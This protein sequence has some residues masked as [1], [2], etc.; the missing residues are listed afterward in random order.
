MKSKFTWIFTLL[1]AF[2]IQFS[3]AQDRVITGVV[4]DD[5]GFPVPGADVMISGV[6]P[7]VQTD[8][9]GKFSINAKNGDKLVVSFAGFEA[10]TITV[11]NASVL[12][13]QLGA[14]VL[15]DV[16]VEAY[17]TTSKA[18]SSI[19]AATVTSKT[20]ENR[21]NASFVQILQ[22]QV[23]G[24][25]ISSGSGQPGANNTTV[26]LRGAGSI[27]GNIEPL[28]VIDGVPQNSDN[29]RSINPAD[30]ES[31]SVLKDA[32]ATSIYG[33]RGANGV[34]IVKTKRGRYD[35]PLTIKYSGIT[36]FSEMQKSRYDVLNSQQLLTLQRTM[37]T[38][39]GG[40]I[41]PEALGGTNGVAL[42]D[43]QIAAA[44][45]YDWKDYFF[46]TG[47]SQNHVL[48]LSNGSKNLSSFT[49]LAFLKQEGIL[50][51]TDL[52]RFNFRSNLNGKSDNDKFN[53]STSLTINYSVSNT[54]SNLGSGAVNQNFVVG[55]VQG[56]PYLSPANYI[57]G[58]D[59]AL[60][61]SSLDYT[62]LFLYDKLRNF[63]N[64][65]D[66]VKAIGQ[67]QASY[68]ITPDLTVGSTFGVD[69]TN[70]IGLSSQHPNGFTPLYFIQDTPQEYTG[71]Q[72]ESFSR[73]VS[74]TTNT[75]LT[76]NKTFAEKHT[77]EAS[78]FTEYFKAHAKGFGYTQNGLDPIFF[79]PGTS[80]GW[81]AYQ[82]GNSYYVPDASSS[83]A[84]AGLFSYFGSVDYDYDSRFGLNA[85]VRRDASFRFAD[86]NKWGTFWSVSG[87]WNIDR[88][89]FMQGS[90][91]DMLKLRGS[92]G[93]AGNQDITGGGVFG[94]PSLTRFQYG[95]SSGY[96]NNPAYA[97][98][99]LRNPDLKWETIRQID[100]G[101][102]FEL[103]NHK[104]RGVADV[105]DKK[106]TDLYQPVPI[107]AVNGNTSINSNFG[108]LRNR[109]VELQLS[110]DV[111]R[112]K[113]YL[114]TLNFNGSYNK[115][116]ILKL[117]NEDGLIWDGGLTADREG[118]VISQYYLVKY[119][120]VNPA[121]G[122]L[123]FY[124][125]DGALTES[126]T[127][128]DRKFN[129]KSS[130]PKYQGS[131]GLDAEYK[132]FFINTMFTYVADIYRFDY[133]LANLLDP[134]SIGNFNKSNSLLNYWTPD[135][136]VTDIPAL[137]ATNKSLDSFSDRN[138]RD[139]SYLRMRYASVG[140]NFSK[141]LL[142]KTPFT[143]IRAYVQG[144]NYLTWTKWRGFDAESNRPNDQ[145]Q[146]PTPKTLSIGV[147]VQF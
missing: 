71:D 126:P 48:N 77:F 115:N 87:R 66:E 125:K 131:F 138:L 20:I 95:I 114:I 83:K 1:L 50:R 38:G 96:N 19:A 64:Q 6:A 146:Y 98:T 61:H 72:T 43:A 22:G 45:N 133:D 13:I 62:P 11:G 3:F 28:Y 101:V 25:N 23:P 110:Y 89:E 119:A 132:G 127:D 2:F 118:D 65:S 16:I 80:R 47:V 137:N 18:K 76:Y 134:A 120:G 104:L 29:F 109:G 139:A 108:S 88:E 94:S 42:T 145:S 49:S 26:I 4:T 41:R 136:R 91:F 75:N 99:T 116:E 107:S 8:F 46:R 113:D 128:A 105:Y 93:T 51:G 68:K 85:T 60:N 53:Y 102:D 14:K 52:K 7:G 141:E 63:T 122:N 84:E 39:M 12:N 130:L 56:V 90:V 17:R 27:N 103:F 106:T 117:A 57:S 112:G 54:A 123:L 69:Y 74:F 121:N 55:A 144:E 100:F 97:L 124:D 24:L 44:P 31:A 21:P 81:I 35:A 143:S 79:S 140:Y 30:I 40:G 37:N 5:Q 10:Q 32:G 147:E 70:I 36:G 58:L 111:L 33:N 15:D 135:N 34:I 129:N 78:V 9:E 67:A 59:L 82:S 142:E 92:I 86:S 73:S